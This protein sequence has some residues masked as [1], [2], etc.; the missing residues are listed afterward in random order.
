[1]QDD[2]ARRDDAL[3]SDQ[4]DHETTGPGTTSGG[5]AVRGARRVETDEAEDDGDD[6]A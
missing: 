3:P 4:P 6:D 5:G 2:D 1:M